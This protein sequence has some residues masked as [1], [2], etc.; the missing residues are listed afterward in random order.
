MEEKQ[1]YEKEKQVY[2]TPK[3]KVEE[4]S[5]KETICWMPMSPCSHGGGN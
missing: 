5:E 3:M 1:T 4:I 2:E